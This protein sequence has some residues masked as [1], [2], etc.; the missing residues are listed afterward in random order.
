MF[1]YKDIK[2]SCNLY[3]IISIIQKRERKE[4]ST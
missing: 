3:K 4:E 1:L 2:K